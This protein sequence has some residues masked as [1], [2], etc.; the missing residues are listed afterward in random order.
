MGWNVLIKIND[1]HV[2]GSSVQLKLT[3]ETLAALVCTV[4]SFFS[5]LFRYQ[6]SNLFGFGMYK[7]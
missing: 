6:Q 7:Q 2:L 3:L 4:Y 5:P 1:N